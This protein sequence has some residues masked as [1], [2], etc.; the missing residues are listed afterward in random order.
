MRRIKI[1]GEEEVEKGEIQFKKPQMYIIK[2]QGLD[3]CSFSHPSKI[4]T[5]FFQG[6]GYL[7]GEI[8]LVTF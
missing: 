6:K 1:R 4:E 8:A 2:N 3:I 7:P 5:Q